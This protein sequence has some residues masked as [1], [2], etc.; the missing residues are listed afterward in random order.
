MYMSRLAAIREF[1]FLKA[2][3]E[4]G[5]PVPTPYDQSR[6]TILM[7]FVPA[8]PFG[9]FK[10]IRH[11]GRTYNT[12]LNLIV[13]LAEHGLIHADF[14]EFNLLL[15]DDEDESVTLIDF[16]QM[17]STS[18]PDARTFFERDVGCVVR[19][20]RKRFGYEADDYPR[21]DD[22]GDPK[23]HPKRI[24]LDVE[25]AASGAAGSAAAAF[26]TSEEQRAFESYITGKTDASAIAAAASASKSKD[27]EDGDDAEHEDG[28]E[29]EDDVDEEAL[30]ASLEDGD[31]SGEASAAPQLLGEEEAQALRER[32]QKQEDEEDA[33]DQQARNKRATA[34]AAAKKSKPAAAAAASASA[35]AAPG[36]DG[37][38]EDGEDD[39][40]EETEEET[41]ARH[42]ERMARK[43]ARKSA[44]Q[45]KQRQQAARKADEKARKERERELAA[46]P[47]LAAQ[48]AAEK[49]AAAAAAAAAAAQ[50]APAASASAGAAL[51]EDDEVAELAGGDDDA[52]AQ[53]HDEDDDDVDVGDFDDDTRSM[54]SHAALSHLSSSLGSG[55]RG[56]LNIKLKP[57]HA[58]AGAAAGA[59]IKQTNRNKGR[60][61][62]KVHQTIKEHTY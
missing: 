57:T 20:F 54:A 31:E 53:Q 4:H 37:E 28:E 22:Y 60:E 26:C 33:A 15:S 29:D 8:T 49:V 55:G 56:V 36:V 50:A 38:E 23:K 44:L 58:G 17:V 43:D 10:S 13:R 46:N 27:G 16:P 48:V 59:R 41:E 1:S 21:W 12:L 5:F 51:N 30:A 19:Y 42:R 32:L 34:A 61:M 47:Q 6:H 25:L 3:F 18:H 52:A 45:S 14:N 40:E 62:R 11:T 35:A 2:L 39:E 7:S 24:D 9:Q